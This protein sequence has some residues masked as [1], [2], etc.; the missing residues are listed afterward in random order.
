MYYTS[1]GIILKGLD[2][3]DGDKIVT[4]FSE[5][6]GKIKAIARGVKKNRSSLRACVQ[7]FCHSFFHFRRGKEMDL[8]T[9]GKLLDFYGNLR[10][11]MQGTLQTVYIME[12]ID[13]VTLER[14]PLPGFY[15]HLTG[16]LENMNEKGCHPLY[17]RYFELLL[18]TALGYR[19]IWH[20]CMIC[21]RSDNI[22]THFNIAEGGMICTECG[23]G[24]GELFL[25]S[26]ESLGILKNLD[27]V[28]LPVIARIKA[29]PSSLLQLE[30]IL[31]KYMEYHLEKHFQMKD[32]IK[33][34]KKLMPM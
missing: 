10:E 1:R 29:S 16:L 13:Q 26:G 5:E 18:L 25:L 21:N 9:Q 22:L 20:R 15:Q 11:D 4:V 30:H 23:T 2:Y 27:Q 17:I 6:A 32:T 14:A 31:E 8:I 12:V 34:L 28:P 19:P 33:K 3:R 24:R 7:T